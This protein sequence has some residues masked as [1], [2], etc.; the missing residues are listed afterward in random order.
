MSLESKSQELKDIVAT[1]NTQ[2]F[3][4]DL[5][6]LMQNIATGRA[7]DQLGKLSS[8]MRQLY[9]LGGLLVTSD[10]SNAVH[11]QHSPEKWYKIV[12]LLN[13]IEAEYYQIFFPLVTICVLNA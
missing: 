10:S 13:E 1:Y 12:N 6:G 8:P 5:S 3:L 4:G 11:I 2:W 7:N 9:F